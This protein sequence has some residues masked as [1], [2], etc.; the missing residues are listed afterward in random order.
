M[1]VAR[2]ASQDPRFKF[3]SELPED[4][5]GAFLSVPILCRGHVVGVINLQHRLPHTHTRREI[6]LIST[7]GFLVSAEIE[8]ARLESE[9]TRLSEQ[10]ETRE[11]VERAKGILQRE[12]G[13][14]CTCLLHRRVEKCIVKPRRVCDQLPFVLAKL[15]TLTIGSTMTDGYSGP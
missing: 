7:I 8:A 14:V 2:D 9:I 4:R 15:R 11:I 12:L 10:L 5:Y 13:H 1:A 6:K 3:F